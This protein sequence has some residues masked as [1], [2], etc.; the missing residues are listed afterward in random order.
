MFQSIGERFSRVEVRR[1]SRETALQ[2]QV[3]LQS[4]DVEHWSTSIR[5][6]AGSRAYGITQKVWIFWVVMSQKH[7]QKRS[8]TFMPELVVLSAHIALCKA[9]EDRASSDSQSKS[10]VLMKA[11]DKFSVPLPTFAALQFIFLKLHCQYQLLIITYREHTVVHRHDCM[12]MHHR[13][14]HIDGQKMKHKMLNW[15]QSI[16]A[17]IPM[18]TE[19]YVHSIQPVQA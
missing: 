7:V 19:Q 6:N 12:T 2:N 1:P 10:L 8:R 13:N 11:P 9:P 3:N 5:I 17:E 18:Y 15:C 4:L 14:C 16:M